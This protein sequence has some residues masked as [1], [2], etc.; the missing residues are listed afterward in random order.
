[1]DSFFGNQEL[2]DRR[3]QRRPESDGRAN[4]RPTCMSSRTGK[5]TVERNCRDALGQIEDQL[6]SRSFKTRRLDKHL[7]RLSYP[8]TEDAM[9]VEGAEAGDGGQLL[10]IE[11]VVQM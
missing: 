6:R 5:A 8:R 3:Q 10:Q 11:L 9:K 1:M 4:L 7:D 2:F